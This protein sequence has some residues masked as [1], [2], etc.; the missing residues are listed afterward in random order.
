MLSFVERD[1]FSRRTFLRV[2]S[3][4]LAG[5]SLQSLMATKAQAA[6]NSSEITTG[7]SV[8]FLFQQ[9]GPSQFET[10]DPKMT[11]PEGVR[12]ATG[13]TQTSLAGVQFGS[14]LENIARY[15]HRLAIVR[16]FQT[17]RGNHDI[18]PL[19]C[20]ETLDANIGSIYSR[21]VGPTRPSGMPTNSAIF[22]NAVHAES[23]GPSNR[24][25][26]FASTGSLGPAFAPFIPGAGGQLQKDMTL[27]VSRSRLDNRRALLSEV[28]TLR[29]QIDN[30]GT[31]EAMEG[32][33][34]QAIEV[35]LGGISRAF[36]LS[37]EDPRTVARYDTSHLIR[38]SLWE[39]KN[40][41]KRYTANAQT[42][43]KLLLLARRLCE[44][45]CGFVTIN[46]DFVWDMHAD[47]N[48]LGVEP[49][50]QSVG[51]P[52]D[53]A[54]SAF[55]EDIEN[56]GLSDKIMLVM[57]GEMG[58]TPRVNN[59]GGRDHW[60]RLTPLAIYGGGIRGG[61][62]IGRSNNNGGEP[63][64]NPMTSSNLVATILQTMFNTTAI[65]L[66]DALPSDVSRLITDGHPIPGLL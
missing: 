13:V 38:P 17:S 47:G 46:T 34:S 65:R 3:L 58:R 51:A 24:F 37:H 28:D 14:T 52:F 66:Q 62:V 27:N 48:N 50:M 18:K 44:A 53:H 8:I 15:A 10:F 41:K 32:F 26:N 11:A 42:L 1:G 12:C 40:N 60:G 4:G 63:A 31:M 59:R 43:G 56:R 9:G 49:G 61:Q 20:S 23:P 64:T 19:V 7:K 30:N 29:R 33:Q 54:V 39:R 16:S 55:I 6:Q 5:L 2:G 22:P 57:T 45:G 35:V 36:D 21:V 25:G